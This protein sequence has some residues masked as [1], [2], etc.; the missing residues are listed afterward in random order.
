MGMSP[1]RILVLSHS[2]IMKPYRRKFALIGENTD[3]EIRVVTPSRWYESFQE[4]VF[5]PDPKTCCDEFPQPVRF[6]GYSS[7]FYYR[8]GLKRHFQ[9][10]QPHIIHLEEEAWSLNALQ[11][12]HLKQKYCPH[13]RLI[14]RTS[15]SIPTKQ[16]FGFLPVWIERRIFREAAASFPLSQNAGKILRQRGYQGKLIPI[17]NGVDLRLFRKIEA[18]NPKAQLGLRGG[19]V[20]GYVG[21]LLHMKGLDTL[22]E[23]AAALDFDYQLLIVGR[24]EYKPNLIKLADTLGMANRIVWVDGVQPEN[25]PE[26]INCMDTLVLPSRTTPGWVEF[27]GRVLIEG[28]ACEVPVIG[29]DSGEIPNV[30]GDA[31]L[32]FQ[33]G[34]TRALADRFGE[35]ARN[36]SLRAQCIQRGSERVKR[37]MWETIAQETYAVYRDLVPE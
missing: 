21:R 18:S 19:F 33:E 13:S 28:M 23:A 24:G 32:I 16:R 3:V 5:K 14:F 15:L 31:G 4:I 26:F 36:E 20:I 6:S 11:T 35:I 12:L 34:D 22:L 7:R 2:Y 30:I 9:G 8:H 27:F 29:S 37:F 10:F 1:L 25:V 17:S